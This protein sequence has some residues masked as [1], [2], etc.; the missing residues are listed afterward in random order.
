M[1]AYGDEKVS[2]IALEKI[3]AA[4]RAG[5]ADACYFLSRAYAEGVKPVEKDPAQAAQ[6]ELAAAEA[7]HADARTDLGYA[8][9][10]GTE[11]TPPDYVA[12]ER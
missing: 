2:G 1:W 5:V 11:D 12:A 8:A 7:G 10:F 6:W 4:A 9:L 3:E